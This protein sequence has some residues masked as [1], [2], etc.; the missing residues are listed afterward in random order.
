MTFINKL[1][2]DGREP[3]ELLDE[4]EKVLKI[5]CAPVTWP[6]GMGRDLKGI[7]HLLEDRIY[8]YEA[9]ERGRA[10]TNL[11]IDAISSP[12]AEEFLGDSARTLRDEIELVH[13]ATHRFDPQLYLAGR[14]TPVFFGSAINN[15]GV[16]ELLGSFVAH[17]PAPRPRETNERQVSAA[18]PALTGFV[19]KIQ[20]NM[21][22][23][24]DS[25]AVPA[26]TPFKVRKSMKTANT[27]ATTA[28][29]RNEMLG[30]REL[31]KPITMRQMMRSANAPSTQRGR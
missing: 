23:I 27:M 13:G 4:I 6:I 17:A 22:A 14:Q 10:G 28:T 29:I 1:D 7:Y 25:S 2:R 24:S 20:A 3:V 31:C 21:A 8:V 19:F 30:N 12:A 18:E 5:N 9:A 26:S 11:T 16:Q 15:F